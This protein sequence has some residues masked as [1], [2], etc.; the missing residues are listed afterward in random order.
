MATV[1]LFP[2]YKRNQRTGKYQ[3]KYSDP[4]ASH[5]ASQAPHAERINC[6]IVNQACKIHNLAELTSQ[7]CLLTV[8]LLLYIGFNHGVL[9]LPENPARGTVFWSQNIEGVARGDLTEKAR[10]G[11]GFSAKPSNPWLK[12]IIACSCILMQPNSCNTVKLLAI[13]Q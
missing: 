3:Y 4:C 12:P 1:V 10:P 11:A 9:G 5:V 13:V 7:R 8:T 6:F 2:Y